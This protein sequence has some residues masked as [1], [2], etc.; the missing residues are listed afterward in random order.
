MD[1][2]LPHLLAWVK[3]G[4]HFNLGPTLARLKNGGSPSSTQ[5]HPAKNF[6]FSHLAHLMGLVERM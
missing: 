2:E 3:L 6:R 1:L 4:G 5:G